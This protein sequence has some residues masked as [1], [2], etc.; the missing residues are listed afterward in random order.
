MVA[1]A[2]VLATS[3]SIADLAIAEQPFAAALAY[4]FASIAAVTTVVA[5]A[6]YI[7]LSFVHCCCTAGYAVYCYAYCS[8]GCHHGL[9]SYP[10]CYRVLHADLH[11]LCV[12]I[13]NHHAYFD[14]HH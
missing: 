12:G 8:V 2:F 7:H 9:D 10:S 4:P 5:A 11:V 6:D 14:Y 1:F 3:S 13:S